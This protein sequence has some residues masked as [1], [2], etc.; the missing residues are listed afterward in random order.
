ASASSL[1]LMQQGSQFYVQQD[2]K[3]AAEYYQQALDLEKQRQN[4]SD[5]FFEV[6]VDNLGMSYGISGDLDKAKA[7]LK[8]GITQDPKYPLFHYNMACAYGE[9]NKMPQALSELQIAYANRSH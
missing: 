7:T 8:Y 1:D 3:K 4:L 6:L 5:T 9:Q 2:Y